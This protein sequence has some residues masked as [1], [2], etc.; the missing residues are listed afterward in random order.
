MTQAL[1][2]VDLYNMSIRDYRTY[3]TLPKFSPRDIVDLMHSDDGG[4]GIIGQEAACRAV[5]TQI[6]S[7]F[8][9]CE[10][11]KRNILLI[12]PTGC[13]K[14]EIMRFVSKQWNARG[15]VRC[16]DSSQINATGWKGGIKLADMLR[17]MP[18]PYG[19]I[20]F[21]DEFDKLVQERYA[22][23]SS[24]AWSV[25]SLVQ[26]QLL[27]LLDHDKLTVGGEDGRPGFDV[28]G[29][30]ITVICMGAFTEIREKKLR[31][32]AKRHIGFTD[33]TVPVE[34]DDEI[35][36]TQDDLIEYGVMPEIA[37]RL[38]PVYMPPISRSDMLQIAHR[39][40]KR[41]SSGIFGSITV[42]DEK[43]QILANEAYESGGGGR[44]I[45]N[46]LLAMLDDALFDNPDSEV[47]VL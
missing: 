18:E 23:G 6:Y 46:R 31:Q 44:A 17:D 2:A 3:Q 24:G 29:Q 4:G 37:N 41:L 27:K 8:N 47:F 40:V 16:F 36:I 25:N 32:K 7:H 33:H 22:G 20:L 10:K 26:E 30:H 39:E 11:P 21:L 43:L 9:S 45:R 19:M 1:G 42:P 14:S 12:G 35:T 38:S 34:T 15:F 13:G 28:Y 5:A